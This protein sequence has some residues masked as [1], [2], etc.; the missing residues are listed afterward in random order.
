MRRIERA[1]DDLLEMRVLAAAASARP[2]LSVG[3][4]LRGAPRSK[5]QQP[6]AR[7]FADLIHQQFLVRRFR[8]RHEAAQVGADGEVRNANAR[9]PSS[10]SSQA[11]NRPASD[12]RDP[13]PPSCSGRRHA[14][15]HAIESAVVGRVG[16]FAS[17]SDSTSSTLTSPSASIVWKQ[18]ADRGAV[19]FERGDAFASRSSRGVSLRCQYFAC[20]ASR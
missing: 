12:R 17:A 7:T 10:A 19:D 13:R 16:S 6:R 1:V 5:Q 20:A 8:R 4:L 9:R 3:E 15:A 11:Q 2:R 14:A 18:R